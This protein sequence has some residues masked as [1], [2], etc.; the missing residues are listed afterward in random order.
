M[1]MEVKWCGFDYGQCIMEPGGLR[2]P[3]LFGDI[4][5][6]LGKPEL[7]PDKIKKYRV[8]KE[9]YG[10]YGRI[11]EGH[12]DE[13]YSYVLDDDP[14]AVELFSTKEQ[15]LLDMGEGMEA[16]L[17]YLQ[18]QGIELQVV[19]EMKK[20]LGPVGTDI[21]SRFLKRRGLVK[22]F[23]ELVTPQGKI[24]LVDDS[25]DPKYKGH[26]KKAG[27]LYDVLAEE[28]RERGISVDEAVMI[29]DKP[30][31]DINP[32]HERG[33]KTIKYTGF[34]DLGPSK[35]DVEISHFSELIQLIKCKKD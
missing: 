23:K 31:T 9:K 30:A 20:T 11:K 5:K 8:L 10:S 33:F 19:S 17:A 18:N 15:E 3:L 32:A 4:Y 28:L 16:A 35:A 6:T 25:V 27:T 2:N 1:T 21:V 34:I 29:G 26:T 12:R 24:N 22:Y 7:I 14:E 13:I